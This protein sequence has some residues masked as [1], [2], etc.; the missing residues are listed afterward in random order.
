MNLTTFDFNDVAEGRAT[1]LGS[2]GAPSLLCR[3]ER[4]VMRLGMREV[5]A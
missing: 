2:E 4:L 5:Q 3:L 1:F